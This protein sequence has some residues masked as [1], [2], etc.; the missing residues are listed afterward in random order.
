MSSKLSPLTQQ[1]A[2]AYPSRRGFRRAFPGGWRALA[3]AT[4]ATAALCLAGCG[5]TNGN[6][7]NY[8]IL[9]PGSPPVAHDEPIGPP[10]A[11]P[12]THPGDGPQESPDETPPVE[13]EG[14]AENNEGEAAEVVPDDGVE[15]GHAHDARR[16][17]V[18]QATVPADE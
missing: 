12:V 2:P 13:P 1:A 3:A 5:S 11:P 18:A 17:G 9:P 6:G 7:D 8:T 16:P 15:H 14:S 10:G 4:G